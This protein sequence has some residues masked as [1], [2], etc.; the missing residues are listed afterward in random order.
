M[1]P[2]EPAV[3]L[4]EISLTSPARPLTDGIDLSP[5]SVIY[6]SLSKGGITGPKTNQGKRMAKFRWLEIH[7][8]IELCY[9]IGKL[10]ETWQRGTTKNEKWK[11]GVLLEW[12]FGGG[13]GSVAPGCA[14]QSPPATSWRGKTGSVEMVNTRG[15]VAGVRSRQACDVQLETD[16]K[17]RH[18]RG[19]EYSF[20]TAF[21]N[22]AQAL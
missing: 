6:Y 7:Q 17:T 19:A 21:W 1:G 20:S 11:V 5:C 4:S 9:T 16:R 8:V 22:S 18:I 14:N 15:W 10:V 12:S 2:C 13:G 3:A